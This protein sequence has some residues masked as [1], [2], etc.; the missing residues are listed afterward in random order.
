MTNPQRRSADLR[1]AFALDSIQEAQRLI[2]RAR[3]AL[4]S[5][6]GMRPQSRAIAALAGTLTRTWFH[7]AATASRLRGRRPLSRL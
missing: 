7:T 1:V 6:E 3:A 2:E 5:V 4:S